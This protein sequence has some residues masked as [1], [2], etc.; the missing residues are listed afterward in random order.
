MTRWIVVLTVLAT[1]L[2]AAPSQAGQIYKWTDEN[3]VVHFS[4]SPVTT[5]KKANDMEVYARET[6][7]PD[8]FKRGN[9]SR[10]GS[11]TQTIT[12]GTR[13]QKPPARTLF[14][15]DGTMYTPTGNGSY[16]DT[17]TGGFL[18]GNG[19]GGAF[20]SDGTF[21]VPNGAG[22]MI[23]TRTGQPLN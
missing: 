10:S 4:N 11:Y 16:I 21:Y 17:R 12:G 9:T 2:I 15:T 1:V 14:G 13:R 7:T 3:G 8:E 23:N 18:H 20:G 22:G 19:A 5:N 6:D